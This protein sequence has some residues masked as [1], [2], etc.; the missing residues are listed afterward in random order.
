MIWKVIKELISTNEDLMD[1]GL[2]L[3]FTYE[4][5]IQKRGNNFRRVADVAMDLAHHWWVHCT[6]TVDR[7]IRILYLSCKALKKEHLRATVDE[8]LKRIH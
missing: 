5:I 2:H 4:M 7:K 1:F 6:E 8:V 3:G